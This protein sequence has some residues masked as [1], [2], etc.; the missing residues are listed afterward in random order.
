MAEP[1]PVSVCAAILAQT[2][3]CL[4]IIGPWAVQFFQWVILQEFL[5]L[6]M[7]ADIL[8]VAR[9]K[10]LDLPV[11]RSPAALR[12]LLAAGVG[13]GDSTNRASRTGTCKI[14]PITVKFNSRGSTCSVIH[15]SRRHSRFRMALRRGRRLYPPDQRHK[16]WFSA[17]TRW[18]ATGRLTPCR[19][20]LDSEAK[21][22][23]SVIPAR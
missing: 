14:C 5:Q 13:L 18:N 7:G 9:G 11:P 8:V 15:H 10:L 1:L 19:T 20:S 6:R 21:H 17:T 22:L 16:D 4:P 3:L 23:P 2:T 12:V